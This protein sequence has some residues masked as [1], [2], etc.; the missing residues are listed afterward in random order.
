MKTATEIIAT[1]GIIRKDTRRRAIVPSAPGGPP[2]MTDQ[3]YAWADVLG[4]PTA[5]PLFEVVAERFRGIVHG[6]DLD[7]TVEIE[8]VLHDAKM[9]VLLNG[10]SNPRAYAASRGEHITAIIIAAAL[11]YT[12]INAANVIAFNADGSF[13]L[14]AT[15]ERARF[16]RLK[17]QA[18]QHGIV[19]GGFYGTLPDGTIVTFSRGGSDVT[20]A[21]I[22]VC[23]GG[24]YENWTDVSGIFA[25]DPRIVNNP[26]Q[27]TLLTYDEMGELAYLNAKIHY[28]AIP[29]VQ[30]YGV[31]INIRNFAKPDDEGTWIVPNLPENE[32]RRG[33][34]VG[35]AGRTGFTVIKMK[36]TLM[37]YEVGFF[38]RASNVMTSRGVNIEHMPTSVD[39]LCI[40]V[41]GLNLNGKLTAVVDDL[42][43]VCK[44]DAIQVKEGLALICVVGA[45]F[46]DTPGVAAPILDALGKANINVSMLLHGASSNSL[47]LGVADSD[48][49]NAI[50]AIYNAFAM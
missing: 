27:Q 36:K 37:N 31:P 13:N 42:K 12:F 10:R 5:D 3:L 40:V 34:I 29:P 39:T 47:T 17:E 44:P 49:A 30:K 1:L 28:E 19:I 35:I 32:R 43:D 50:R 4:T 23:L 24:I 38:E 25:A 46:E 11:G 16:I 48:Y 20:G 26:R 21:A 33:Q 41:W 15:R 18:E 6:L 2:K 9:F 8:R 7:Q 14:E 22:A 45:A